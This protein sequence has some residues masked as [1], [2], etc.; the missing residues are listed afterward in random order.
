MIVAVL[1]ERKKLEKKMVNEGKRKG[2]LLIMFYR[3]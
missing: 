1:E 3:I 2:E